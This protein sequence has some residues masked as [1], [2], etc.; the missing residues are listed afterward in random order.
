MLTSNE[1]ARIIP[2]LNSIGAYV[3]MVDVLSDGTFRYFAFN[4]WTKEDITNK[5]GITVGRRPEEV[6]DADTAARINRHYQLCVKYGTNIVY[7]DSIDF[8]TGR[9]WASHFLAPIFDLNGNIVRIMATVIETTKRKLV[10]KALRESEERYHALYDN[11]PARLITI[12]PDGIILSVNQFGAH[13]TGYNRD[14][15]INTSIFDYVHADD[16]MKVKQ[17]LSSIIQG[18]DKLHHAE[19]RSI[20]KDESVIW[21]SN[22]ARFSRD[23]DGQ[24][25][26][27]IVSEDITK[28][29]KL[30]EELSYQATHDS[31]TGLVNRR[32]FERRLQQLL[33][34]A[35]IGGIQH[36]LCYLDLDQ[37]KIINDVCGHTAGDELLRQLTKLLQKRIH[38]N[39]CLAR[40]G[41]DEFGVLM[42]NSSLSQAEAMGK[43]LCQV[44][45][46]Y[47]FTWDSKSFRIGVSIGVVPITEKSGGISAAL[48]AADS[49]C[50]TAKDMGRNQIHVYNEDDSRMK[51]RHGQMEW[52]NRINSAISE[53]R[54]H[55]YYQP[56]IPVDQYDNKGDCYELLLRIE[57]EYGEIIS[58]DIFMPAAERFCLAIKLDEWVIRNT[59]EW[60]VSNPNQLNNLATC[61]INLSG[62]T[63]GND[64]FLDFIIKQ[65]DYT[66]IP[67]KKI[68]FEITETTAITNITD[69]VKFINHLRKIGCQFSLDDFGSGMSSLTYLKNFPVNYLKIDGSFV[70]NIVDDPIDFAIVKS[71]N[72]I[73]HT[74]GKKTIAEFVENDAIFNKLSEIGI[75]FYQG[76]A[77][78]RPQPIKLKA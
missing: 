6:F 4:R 41:G 28:A 19:F 53:G 23:R 18:T 40:L 27:L 46:D 45:Q 25:V 64:A 9:R 22:T 1:K 65:F 20:K 61:F 77:I 26:I 36:A 60:L 34:T 39:D 70:K 8:P 52:I 10:E 63:L 30:A 14:E 66:G 74:M 58:S 21:M 32:E 13:Y 67:C 56:I 48:R 51:I 24:P 5:L 35:E 71:I 29:H 42:L 16:R 69:A 57:D 73:G 62:A 17:F 11:N 7:E 49:A 44:V 37:F 15:L 33:D 2:I 50:Y 72:D 78:A 68:C 38:K 12:S 47:E 75:D 43:D 59:F 76:Y 55:L 3:Y 54:L 31:L